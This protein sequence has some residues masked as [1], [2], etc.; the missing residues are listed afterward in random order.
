MPAVD[1]STQKCEYSFALH[2]RYDCFKICWTKSFFSLFAEPTI[3]RENL[4]RKLKSGQDLVTI[5]AVTFRADFVGFSTEQV[6]L[7]HISFLLVYVSGVQV[8]NQS[9]VCVK[10]RTWLFLATFSFH[11]RINDVLDINDYSY[12]EDL[13]SWPKLCGHQWRRQNDNWGGGGEYSYMCV[14][15]N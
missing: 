5:D 11:H 3:K 12:T 13:Q 6:F 14:L 1:C 4:W 15:L 9:S 7:Q 8:I 2:T 10:W